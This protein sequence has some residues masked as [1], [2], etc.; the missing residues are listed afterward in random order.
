MTQDPQLIP[1][2]THLCAVVVAGGQGS[3]LGAAQPKGF[4][5][6]GTRPLV[7]YCLDVF[8]THPR[9]D[10]IVLVAPRS[11]LESAHSLAKNCTTPC[12]VTPGGEERWESVRNGVRCAPQEADWILVHDAARPFVTHAVIDAI[13]EKACTYLGVVTATPIT[14]T[15]R[16]FEG[17]RAGRTV[18]RST[19]VRV[20]TPQLFH[21][22]TLD[23]AFPRATTLSSPPTDEAVLLEKTGVAVGIAQGNP[24]NFKIT[25]PHDFEIAHALLTTRHY[26]QLTATG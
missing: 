22:E 8:A 10:A 16:D 24:I 1:P 7:S 9:I 17:D 23:R 12:T 18:D 5:N 13:L 25:T 21:R 11:H 6:L 20:G 15:V 3:R 19:L 26:R 14:D 2:L 4:V